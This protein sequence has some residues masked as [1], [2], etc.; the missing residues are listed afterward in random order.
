MEG[1]DG[2]VETEATIGDT[3]GVGSLISGLF[4]SNSFL[5]F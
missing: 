3:A 5:V 4:N 2:V 1:Q